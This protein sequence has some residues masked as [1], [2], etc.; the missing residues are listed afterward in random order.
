MKMQHL[1]LCGACAIDLIAPRG[2]VAVPTP[3]LGVREIGATAVTV[4]NLS[5]LEPVHVARNPQLAAVTCQFPAPRS[6]C[7]SHVSIFKLQ[8]TLRYS[9]RSAT[10]S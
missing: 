2:S 3:V 7:N 4:P 1:I 6:P 10:F 8:M 5:D 9:H